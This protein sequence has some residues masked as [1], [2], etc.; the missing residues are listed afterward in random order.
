MEYLTV[1]D[2]AKRLKVHSATVKRW[3]RD[4]KLGGFL[5][6]DRTGWRVSEEDLAR[7]IAEQRRA[8]QPTEGGKAAA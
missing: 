7:F 4:G 1:D 5:I 8:S 2:V 3:L 6:S